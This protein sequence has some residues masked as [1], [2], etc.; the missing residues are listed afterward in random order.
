MFGLLLNMNGNSIYKE[1]LDYCGYTPNIATS[2]TF[3]QQRDKILPFAF[4]FLFHEFNE[5][6]KQHKTYKGYRL[7]AVDGSDLNISNLEE[8]KMSIKH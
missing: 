4:E 6:F 2:S 8:K 5:S 1:L 3:V 7:L